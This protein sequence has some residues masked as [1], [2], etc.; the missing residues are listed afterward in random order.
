MAKPLSVS[1]GAPTGNPCAPLGVHRY[2]VSRLSL[3]KIAKWS[4]CIKLREQHKAG[5]R[6]LG[7]SAIA[8]RVPADQNAT[9]GKAGAIMGPVA[10]TGHAGYN[11]CGASP[12]CL[13]RSDLVMRE[14]SVGSNR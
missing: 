9:P 8:F 4:Y 7:A 11:G 2:G 14:E 13:T 1:T 12:E 5:L 6:Y 3:V 10:Q